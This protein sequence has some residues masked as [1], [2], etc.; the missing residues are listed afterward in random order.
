MIEGFDYDDH[1]EAYTLRIDPRWHAMYCNREFALID[2]DKRR[3]FGRNQ[4]MAKTLQRLVATSSDRVQ[5]YALDGLKAKMEYTSPLRKFRDALGLACTELRR[6]EIITA[7]K[8]EDS[9]KGKQQLALWLPALKKRRTFHA[10]RSSVP[11][12]S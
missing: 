5:R 8:I 10:H 2:W 3:E 4:D 12:A 6:L 7:H 11:P 9:S 1:T